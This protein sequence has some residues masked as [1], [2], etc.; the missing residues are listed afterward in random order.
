MLD[1]DDNTGGTPEPSARHLARVR[2]MAADL[3]LD[4]V[5][6][7]AV[8]QAFGTPDAA[9]A[10]MPTARK[11]AERAEALGLQATAAAEQVRRGASYDAA[12]LAMVDQRI[13]ARMAA[14]G[15]E[16]HSFG[17]VGHSWDSGEGLRAKMVDGLTARIARGHEPTIGREFAQMRLGEFAMHSLRRAGLKPFNEAEAVRMAAHTTSDFPLILENSMTNA[18]AR[19][20]EQAQ[21]ALAR[22]SREVERGDYRPGKSLTLS[23]SGVPKEVA[24]G[25]EIEFITMDEKGEALPQ[26]RDFAAGFNITN[27]AL[28]NDNT[29]LLA[30]AADRMVRGAAER[31]RQVL[32]EPLLANSGDGQT[33]ADSNPMFHSTHGNV[34]STGAA[35]DVGSLGLARAA[36]RKQRGLQGELYAI[37]PW[38]LVV[39]AEL[40]TVAQQ[41]VATLA[42]NTVEEANP[43][44]GALQIIVEPG[45]TDPKA[46]YLVADPSRHDGHVHA[47][48]DG[49]RA[50][51]VESR[52]AWTTLGLEMRL[53]WA[54]DAKFIET[55]T[56][57]KNAGPEG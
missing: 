32:L 36:M 49:A 33:M 43:F 5:I 45:L 4:P 18:V 35:I 7:D 40:E 29:G 17:S 30:Q 37:E 21:P 56:W 6:S 15:P 31:W 38:G 51:R 16:L 48:L 3:G 42:A 52:P 11:I 22:A 10:Y 54:V 41:V 25:G 13:A 1:D 19:G 14:E 57:Y 46:W 34:A 9:K 53:V 44:A 23:A 12:N 39:P 27:T 8:A 50:P 47:F 28:V 26:V 20:F 55:A 24:E 2:M